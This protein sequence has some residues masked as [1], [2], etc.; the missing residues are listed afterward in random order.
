[1]SK[2]QFKTESKKLLDLMIN[3]IYTNKDIFLRELIS[4]SSDALDKLL[5]I[6]LTDKNIDVEKDELKINVD[7]DKD[8][9][10]ITITD[11]GIGMDKKELENNLGT[12][13]Q[14]G[15]LL[16]KEEN[17]NNKD[18][19][20]IGQFGVG[21]YSAFMVADKIEVIS[22]K[23]GEKETFKWVSS[24]ASGYEIKEVNESP[25]GTKIT[26]HIKNNTDDFNYDK[27]LDDYEV[28][29]II[30][31]YSNYIT[32]PIIMK[33]ESSVLKEGTKDEYETVLEEK[34]INSMIPLWKKNITDETKEEFDGFYT[35][36]FHDYEKPQKIF[37]NNIEGKINY[38]SLLFIPSHAPYDYY[39]K[40]Y[41]KGLALY[42]NGVLI[43]DKCSELLPDYFNFVKGLVDSPDVSLNISR[44]ILQKDAQISSIAKS[45]E[46]KIEK[47]LKTMIEKDREEYV[48]FFKNFGTNLKFGIYNSFGM[49]KDK[50]VDLIMFYSSKEERLITLKEYTENKKDDQNKIYYA[51]GESID[52]INM[53][54]QIEA[55]KE[56]DIDVLYFDDYID[57]FTVSVLRS[58]DSLEF[59]NIANED[60][61]LSSEEDKKIIEKENTDA[62]DLLT[63]M[64]ESLDGKV[65]DVK[66][67]DRL[68]N[69]PVCLTTK[70]NV[71]TNMEKIINAMPTDESIK[72]E[73]VLEINVNH[74]IVKKL[75][76]V[77]K[78]NKDDIKSY[79][80]ILYEEA[81]LIEGLG[82]ENP[83]ELSKLVC[84]FLSK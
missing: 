52:K 44:E 18:I 62:K 16:F 53:L 77:F 76:D 21:F 7:I 71:S 29:N 63:L 73:T 68:T 55:F 72:S 24:G 69:H 9:R 20:I 4:N 31:K 45:I 48:K 60:V 79:A 67:T 70:G 8:K 34:T 33:V 39:Q 11:N 64:K 14:S 6:S 59:V 1:M 66:F 38:T 80:T 47:E 2:K 81:R 30:T 35:D 22:R 12:I 37:K 27:Y 65:S 23:Y 19:D 17:S 61:S 57:E 40:D 78:T 84:E 36:N 58:Y 26:L 41:E 10:T 83:A 25:W 56:K 32:Y 75:K 82:A 49:N 15:S 51:T 5:F 42:S 46:G 50:L 43:M 3:S 28:Q 13:G 54:P 74:D